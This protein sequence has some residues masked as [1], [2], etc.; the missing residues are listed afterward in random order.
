MHCAHAA[1]FTLRGDFAQSKSPARAALCHE[2]LPLSFSPPCSTKSAK[3]LS[4]FGFKDCSLRVRLSCVQDKGE[5]SFGFTVA[6]ICR[7]HFGRSLKIRHTARPLL[8]TCRP[9]RITAGGLLPASPT[10]CCHVRDFK[11]Q[12]A[13]L[14]LKQ[15]NIQA[16][17]S[18]PYTLECSVLLLILLTI[19]VETM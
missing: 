6:A 1:Y 7:R 16:E 5:D 11:I 2:L 9:Y 8:H 12:G 17:R 3:S 18:T 4:F 14:P 10:A 19:G 15:R 13:R